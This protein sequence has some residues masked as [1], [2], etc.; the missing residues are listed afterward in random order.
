MGFQAL[1]TDLSIYIRGNIIMGINIDD[2]FI[3]SLNLS[4]CNSVISQLTQKIEVINKREINSFF[5]ISITHSYCQH[6]ISIGWFGHMIRLLAKYNMSNAKS[7]TT[8]FEKGT[9]LKLVVI[10]DKLCNLK[11]YQEL[12]GSLRSSRCVYKILYRVCRVQFLQFNA[13]P[14]TIHFKAALHVGRF[15]KSTRNY[16]IVYKCS[17]TVWS[18]ISLAIRM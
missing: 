16:C 4:S 11:L 13:N 8:P 5:D 6:A 17:M 15:L 7:T 1:E 18:P 12:T 10:N 9:K 2:I 3:C 14:T